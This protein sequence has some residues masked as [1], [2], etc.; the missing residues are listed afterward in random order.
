MAAVKRRLADARVTGG[1][2]Y[3]MDRTA[4]LARARGIELKLTTDVKHVEFG[5]TDKADSVRYVADQVARA[6]GIDASDVL[7]ALSRSDN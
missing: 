1:I 7:I 2:Q 3:I 6:N 4:E 5:L